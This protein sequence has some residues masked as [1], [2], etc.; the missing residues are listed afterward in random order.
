[1]GPRRGRIAPRLG[2]GCETSRY[3]FDLRAGREFR[4]VPS[5][6]DRTRG[7][8][9]GTQLG[10]DKGPDKGDRTRGRSSFWNELRPLLFSGKRLAGAV[11]AATGRYDGLVG[12]GLAGAGGDGAANETGIGVNAQPGRQAAGRKGH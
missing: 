10:P 12:I 1:M 11:A 6:W 9:K 5:R 3:F 8:D 7:P 4:L 2:A